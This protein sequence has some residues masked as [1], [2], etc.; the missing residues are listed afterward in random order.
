MAE[1]GGHEASP[2]AEAMMA[3]TAARRERV[4]YLQ[5]CGPRE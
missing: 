5:G 4:R 2:L 3:W 1:G